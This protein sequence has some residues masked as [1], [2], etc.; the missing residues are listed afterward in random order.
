MARANAADLSYVPHRDLAFATIL[1]EEGERSSLEVQ[2]PGDEW[3]PVS[4]D[5]GSVLVLFG[6]M[7]PRLTSGRLRSCRHRVVP[8]QQRLRM[9]TIIGYSAGLE[10]SIRP[11]AGRRLAYKDPDSTSVVGDLFAIFAE[12][13]LP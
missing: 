10:T 7:I 12:S 11:P 5:D 8:P 2:R 6:T 13:S 4:A 1:A 9:T 3:V